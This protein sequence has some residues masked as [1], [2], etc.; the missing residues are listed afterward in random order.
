MT[1]HEYLSQ[2]YVLDRKIKYDLREL[3]NLREMSCSISSP[4][5]GERVSGGGSQ[6]APFVKAL[7][8]IWE[9]EDKINE[10]IKRL[11]ALK[12]EIIGEI[13]KVVDDDERF[14]LL[15]RYVQKMKWSDIGLELCLSEKTVR[16][17]NKTALEKFVVPT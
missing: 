11:E 16:R 9:K 15:Y 5:L 6:E 4:N 2:V 13:N 8:R 14:I 10:E 7:E 17:K 3:E 12:E 1:A